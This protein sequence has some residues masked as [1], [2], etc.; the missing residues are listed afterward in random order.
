M[1]MY[2]SPINLF[3]SDI[4]T[5]IDKRIE[6][7]TVNA[8]QNLGIDIDKDEL[9]KALNYDRKQYGEGYEDGYM[10]GEITGRKD[11]VEELTEKLTK[12]LS[13]DS[14]YVFYDND[15]GYCINT[16]DVLNLLIDERKGES[17]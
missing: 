6:E 16:E 4:A 5:S 2:E 8:I 10:D 14:P 17:E 3:V 11:V 12:L 15:H 1:T 13:A 9:V 7:V